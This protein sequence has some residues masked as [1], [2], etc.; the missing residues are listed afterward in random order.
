MF[1]HG[2][3]RSGVVVLACAALI[4]VLGGCPQTSAPTVSSTDPADGATGVP[5]NKNIAATFS[6]AMDPATITPTTF[7]LM[8]GTTPVSGTVTY[9]GVTAIF[10]P[11]DDLAPNTLYTATI[12]TG[13]E[14]LDQMPKCDACDRDPDGGLWFTALL[15]GLLIAGHALHSGADGAL[16][17]DF[18]WTFTTGPALETFT[19]TYTAG[20]N[21]TISGTSPQTVNSGASGTAVRA[22]P[23][24]G[25]HFV[26]WG[27][28]STQN[29]RTDANVTANVTVSATF[30]INQ[31]TLTYAANAGGTLSGISPQTVNHGDNG[32]LV[33]ATPATGYH[34]TSWSDGVLTAARTDLSV[35]G[36]ITV[37]ASFAINQYT[38][39]YTANAGGTISGISPQTVNHGDNGTLV[40]ANPNAGYH[41]TSWSD[42]VLTAARTDLNVTGDITVSASFAINQYT[43][44]YTANTGGTISGTS[45]QTVDHGGSGT[46]VTATPATGYHFTS[47]S[48]GML[49]AARTELNVTGDITVSASFALTNQYTL[50]YTANV[51]GTISGTSPQTVNQGDSGTLVTATPA[52]GYHFTSWSDGVLTAARTDTNVMA[53]ITVSASFAINQYTLTYTANVGGTIS[54]TS[55]QTVNHGGS[56]SEVTATP[57]TGYHFTSWSDGVLTAARTDTNVMA[58]ITLTASFAIDIIV[59]PQPINGAPGVCINTVISAMF[60]VAMDGLTI[61]TPAVTFTLYNDTKGEAVPGTVDLDVLGTTATFTPDVDLDSNTLY[62]ATIKA[63]VA[64]LD[65]NTLAD[66]FVWG[67][68]T[69]DTTCLLEPVDLGAAAPFGGFGGA[70][71]MT[72]QGTLTVVNGDI[73]TTAASTLI[74]GFH[75]TGGNVYTET[76]LNIG[77]V[78]GTIYTA[79]PAPGTD[80]TFLIATQALADARN[81]Y[82]NV[83]SPAALP[84]GTDPFAGQLGGKTVAPGVYQAAGGSFQI[85]GSDLT[86]D[87][88]EDENAVWVF[89]SA[90]SLTVGDTAPRSVILING[91]QAKNVYWWVGSAATI[92]GAG[93]GTM[94]GTIIAYSG[95]TF[96]TAGNVAL[97]TLNGR[98][99]GL[100]ASVTLVNTII[101]VPAP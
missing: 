98:A 9:T 55:P 84:G 20:A 8:R 76:P 14:A 57:N 44:T 61:I 43:L 3:L 97:T 42:G 7:T 50:T 66:D 78:N 34:F 87:A 92:N 70:A 54:G 75:D 16:A 36:D 45:P 48:D 100:N 83:L 28:A 56:G 91:A 89:Q 27:D 18:V 53:D 4:V 33:T 68:E 40:T 96:S 10:D 86:L 47:W 23:D 46:E 101:N 99:L 1:T 93:G 79:P 6:K 30:A 52:T 77:T 74:T 64:D 12:T 22:V 67:F 63:G 73:G 15:M 38:V 71:G 13:A 80:S 19:L 60:N 49:T 35:T 51:G 26:R 37:S 31:Y 41:F 59:T 90:S 39:T 25:Y 82:D 21:G 69:G 72:N 65:G 62:T 24:T 2:A 81:V 95:V 58:D 17:E 5:V 29:P 94:E 85:T 11:T 88:Q 32:T